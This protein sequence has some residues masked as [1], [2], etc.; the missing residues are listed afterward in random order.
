MGN[1]LQRQLSATPAVLCYVC[2]PLSPSSLATPR[3]Q[4]GV[5][6]LERCRKVSSRP[7]NTVAQYKG[8]PVKQCSVQQTVPRRACCLPVSTPAPKSGDADIS[9]IFPIPSTPDPDV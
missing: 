7:F 5:C 4:V 1:V 6:K 9:Q 8:A 3:M 2:L